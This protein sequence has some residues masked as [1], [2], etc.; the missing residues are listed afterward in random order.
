MSTKIL[1]ENYQ[2]IVVRHVFVFLKN[3]RF[4]KKARIVDDMHMWIGGGG[5]ELR[6]AASREAAGHL[7]C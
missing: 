1:Y 5:G 7:G 3:T 2:K 6:D 4:L